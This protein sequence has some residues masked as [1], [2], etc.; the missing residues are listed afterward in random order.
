MFETLDAI[1]HLAFNNDNKIAIASDDI[2]P[3]IIK[4]LKQSGFSLEERRVAAESLWNQAF[5]EFI[6]KSEKLQS[7][8]P[9][10]GKINT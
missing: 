6:R 2:I 7:A 4:I 5:I 3:D 1:N 9:S 10:T 8:V